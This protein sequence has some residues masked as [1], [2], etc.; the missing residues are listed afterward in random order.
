[1]SVGRAY[2]EESRRRH[3]DE[4]RNRGRCTGG[5]VEEDHNEKY[6]F[7]WKGKKHFISLYLS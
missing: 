3:E 4:I 2:A 7:C 6:S 5:I 1:M